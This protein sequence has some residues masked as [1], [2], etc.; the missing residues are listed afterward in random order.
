M[1]SEPKRQLCGKKRRGSVSI[2]FCSR[3]Q[4]KMGSQGFYPLGLE[5]LIPHAGFISLKRHGIM[6]PRHALELFGLCPSWVWSLCG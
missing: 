3:A 1:M 2:Y 6:A 5:H 4:L